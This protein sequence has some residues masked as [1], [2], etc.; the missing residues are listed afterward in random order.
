MIPQPTT[1]ETVVVLTASGINFPHTEKPKPTN[2]RQDSLKKYLK[3]EVKVTG[4]IQILSGVMVL[5]L[6]IILASASFSEHF[7]SVFSILLKSG[8]PFTGALCFILSGILSIITEKR[9]TKSLVYS[10]LA[11]SI[12]S[13]L[14]A[15]LGFILL[16]V[17]LAALGPA[18]QQ[19]ELNMTSMPTTYYGFPYHYASY[20]ERDCLMAKATLTGALSLMLIYTVLELFLAVLAAVLWWKQAHSDFPGSVLFLPQSYKNKYMSSKVAGGSGYEELLTS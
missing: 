11:I 19:C 4:T 12:L 13:I 1:S 20:E 9:S 3:S 14:S 5:S 6:G 2:Q 18:S 16:F 15:L 7:T 10:S 8:Y 17:N